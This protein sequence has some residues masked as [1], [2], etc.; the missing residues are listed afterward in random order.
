[1]A[2]WADYAYKP[3]I[4]DDESVEER[5]WARL[6]IDEDSVYELAVVF[7]EFNAFDSSE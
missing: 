1:M 7:S 2:F 5:G 6:R 4:S 3:G